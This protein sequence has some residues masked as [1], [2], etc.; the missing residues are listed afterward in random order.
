MKFFNKMEQIINRAFVGEMTDGDISELLDILI[1]MNKIDVIIT[2]KKIV[3]GPLSDPYFIDKFINSSKS[4]VARMIVQFLEDRSARHK[5]KL[6]EGLPSYEEL[7]ETTSEIIAE[8]VPEAVTEP[9]AEPIV[10]PSNLTEPFPWIV[11]TPIVVI[12][13]I[14]LGLVINQIY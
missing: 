12:I 10:A 8:V 9:T 7:N 3:G 2:F 13:S 11:A 6:V 1:N 5:T 4:C 14:I